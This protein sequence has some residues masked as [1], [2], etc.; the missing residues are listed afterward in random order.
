VSA[1]EFA[2]THKRRTAGFPIRARAFA[3]GRSA[4]HRPAG[5]PPGHHSTRGSARRFGFAARPPPAP[6]LPWMANSASAPLLL[7][8]GHGVPQP[9]SPV[10]W[11][12]RR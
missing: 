4:T 12:V 9:A 6:S 7:S 11:L 3:L 2:L 8:D 1:C 5:A 10:G